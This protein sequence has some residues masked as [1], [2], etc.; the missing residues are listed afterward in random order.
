[1]I[2]EIFSFIEKLEKKNG[3]I[4]RILLSTNDVVNT[5]ILTLEHLDKDFKRSLLLV[6]NHSTYISSQ[7]SEFLI[8]LQIYYFLYQFNLK[9]CV[10]SK[11][12]ISQYHLTVHN[13][14]VDKL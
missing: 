5:C 14:N 4:M 11:Q 1:M 13:V 7:L 10:W 8:K 6:L 9:Q 2:L 3:R 12:N